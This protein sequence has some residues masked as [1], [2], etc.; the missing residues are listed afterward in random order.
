MG[1]AWQSGN[2][3]VI[4]AT[5]KAIQTHHA[6]SSMHTATSKDSAM[7]TTTKEKQV[8]TNS[9]IHNESINTVL[10]GPGIYVIMGDPGSSIMHHGHECI[11]T[12]MVD[13]D[14]HWKKLKPI[15]ITTHDAECYCKAS[16]E[17]TWTSST[18]HD[19]APKWA[20]NQWDTIAIERP[21]TPS[22]YKDAPPATSSSMIQHYRDMQPTGS[23]WQNKYGGRYTINIGVAGLPAIT[24]KMGARADWAIQ[25]WEG[26]NLKERAVPQMEHVAWCMDNEHLPSQYRN[27]RATI[28][29]KVRAEYAPIG[30]VI[31]TATKSKGHVAGPRPAKIL[32]EVATCM[33]KHPHSVVMHR[34]SIAI[35]GIG[36]PNS[37]DQAEAMRK[38]VAAISL[39]N[40]EDATVTKHVAG[41]YIINIKVDPTPRMYSD[42][43]WRTR[44]SRLRGAGAKVLV[45]TLTSYLVVD[46]AFNSAM[47][48]KSTKIQETSTNLG[49]NAGSTFGLDVTWTDKL[50]SDGSTPKKVVRRRRSKA[51]IVAATKSTKK[52]GTSSNKQV[53]STTKK[54]APVHMDG[55]CIHMDERA[56]CN[57]CKDAARMLKD[58]TI[59]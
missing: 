47:V 50:N 18:L 31:P 14:T 56:F 39:T 2:K 9:N 1:T 59:G 11:T 32:G 6:D 16:H 34:V 54:G 17:E 36:A 49:H 51:D 46:P 37:A 48:L 22:E 57:I 19:D 5:H 27:N 3:E 30:K 12:L 53:K 25:D 13:R 26:A 43:Q 41:D 45:G 44:T 33:D 15:Y 29:D 20:R 55:A 7:T 40:L 21:A 4:A 28:T 8:L 42:G 10:D 58:G 52:E 38:R 23:I 24:D 35:D